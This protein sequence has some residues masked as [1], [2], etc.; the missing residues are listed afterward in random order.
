MHTGTPLQVKRIGSGKSYVLLAN[1]VGTGLCMWLPVFEAALALYPKMFQ[2]Y[3]FIL[4]CY[5]GL[6]ALE[7]IGS[8]P[9]D[10]VRT[11]LYLT[12]LYLAYS[13]HALML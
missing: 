13:Y 3:S 12:S 4:P 11:L 10:E 5:R 2:D 1:G 9:A 8:A 7:Q 6:F